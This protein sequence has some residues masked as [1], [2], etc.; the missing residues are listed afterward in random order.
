MKPFESK[1][2][3]NLAAGLFLAILLL[4]VKFTINTPFVK[5][6]NPAMA[7]TGTPSCEDKCKRF[8]NKFC[9]YEATDE[10]GDEQIITCR[11][12][13]DKPILGF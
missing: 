10:N 3:R 4:G 1:F 8:F 7:R 9:T 13:K 12:F 2:I 6:A 11:G 5:V